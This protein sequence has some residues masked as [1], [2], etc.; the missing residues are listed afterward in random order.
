[1]STTEGASKPLLTRRAIA[2]LPEAHVRHP[3][4][5]NSDIYLKRLSHSVGLRRL[6]LSIARVP[7]GKE[8]FL[9]HRHERD[10]EFLFIL[11]GRG[12]AEIGEEVF[13]VGAGDFMGFPAPSGPPHHLTNPFRE[14]LVYLMGG[15][16]SG[17]DIGYFPTLGRRLIFT[18]SGTWSVLE[19]DCQQMTF[20]QWQDA[21][22][23]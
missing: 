5:P 4:N 12:R 6:S 18:P 13:E 1:M 21:A 8:N 23:T 3:W 15:E 20:S 19:S 9:Y 10:E 16:S 2:E 22:A 11:S 17:Y 7:P 14:D